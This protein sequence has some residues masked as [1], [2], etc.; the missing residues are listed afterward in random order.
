M[1]TNLPS[2]AGAIAGDLLSFFG[3]PL[4]NAG[5]QTLNFLMTR[6]LEV[7]RG[8]LL[9][10]LRAGSILPN[11]TELSDE[12]AGVLFRYARAAAEGA[13]RRNL[14]LLAQIIRSRHLSLSLYASEFARH[15]E[16]LATLSRDEISF[17]ATMHRV[18]QSPEIAAA[19]ENSRAG[20]I[21][22]QLKTILV[23]RLFGTDDELRACALSLA[24]TGLVL[25]DSA[26]GGLV[27]WPSPLLRKIA[28]MASLE[29]AANEP[30]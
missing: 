4:S 24:R 8:I 3:F 12:M 18:G 5:G 9:E 16:I 30:D 29:A 1:S 20:R 13:A 25:L 2:F 7:A 23:P 26:W 27:F 19:E 11:E 10:E 17:L 28:E 21:G 22:E 15:A 14:R 6:R